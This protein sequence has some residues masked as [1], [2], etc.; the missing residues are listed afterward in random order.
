MNVINRAKQLK[1]MIDK[2]AAKNDIPTI[3]PAPLFPKLKEI[4]KAPDLTKPSQQKID[5]SK[6][7]VPALPKINK[8]GF[9]PEKPKLN[10]NS[11]YNKS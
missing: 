3:P 4:N 2:Q 10:T 7:D 11:P 5:I 1:S 8:T 6:I 9:K